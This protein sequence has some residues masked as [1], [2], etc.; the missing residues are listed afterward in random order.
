MGCGVT[1]LN[2]SGKGPAP[3]FRR[4][5]AAP[6]AADHCSSRPLIVHLQSAE[7]LPPAPDPHADGGPLV[8][9]RALRDGKRHGCE[10]CW[11]AVAADGSHPVW[12]SARGL[13]C[14]FSEVDTLEVELWDTAERKMFSELIATVHIP[15]ADLVHGEFCEHHFSVRSRRATVR[16]KALPPPPARKQVFFVRHGESVWNHA[17]Q[18]RDVATMLG[19]VNHPLTETGRD[20]AV[21][22]MQQIRARAQQP[23]EPAGG[24]E[25]ARLELELLRA[26]AVWSSPLMRAVQTALIAGHPL[27]VGEGTQQRRTLRLCAKARERR[28]FGGRDSTG[29]GRGDGFRELV[30]RSMQSLLPLPN[31]GKQQA[32]EMRTFCHE[33][34]FDLT[35]V[36]AKWWSSSRESAAAVR[37]RMEE[38]LMQLRYCPE[39][40]VVVFG[41]S[42][43][44]RELFR[45]HVREDAAVTGATLTDLCKTVLCNC[46]VAAVLMDFSSG[47]AHPIT[48]VDLIFNSGLGKLGP[49]TPGE[50]P[51]EA[52]ERRDL[53]LLIFLLSAS[54]IPRLDQGGEGES[55]VRCRALKG[56]AEVGREARWP[57]RR[58]EPCPVWNSARSLGCLVGEADH[59]G[60][61]LWDKDVLSDDHIASRKVPLAGLGLD[62]LSEH[63]FPC[64]G[65]E[66]TLRL[67]LLPQPATVKRVYFVRHGES[68]WNHAQRGG[69]LC[70]VVGAVD[71]PLSETGREQATG[72]MEH[73]LAAT[74]TPGTME[75]EMLRAEAVWSSPLIRCV[76]TAILGLHPLLRTGGSQ[77]PLR[78]CRAA[79]EKRNFG[80][81]DTSGAAVGEAYIRQV[82]ERTAALLPLPNSKLPLEDELRQLVDDVG[83]DTAEVQSQWWNDARESAGEL[84]GRMEEFMLQLQ[85]CTE[86]SVVVVGHSLFFREVLRCYMKDGADCVGATARQLRQR[87]L[88]NCGVAAATIDFAAPALSSAVIAVQLLFGSRLRDAE[89]E[90]GEGDAD[91]PGAAGAAAAPPLP[92][93]PPPPGPRLSGT[94]RAGTEE[95]AD[96]ADHSGLLLHDKPEGEQHPCQPVTLPR[97]MMP[98]VPPD[99]RGSG[100]EPCT[101]SDPGGHSPTSENADPAC[102]SG[103]DTSPGPKRRKSKKGKTKKPRDSKQ[104]N[105]QQPASVPADA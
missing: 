28:N 70:S 9:V 85:Y 91:P 8:R 65:K 73:L 30:V 68:E 100:S 36:Q 96:T 13:G 2:G 52:D 47:V 74:Q 82:R 60:L 39:R 93:L 71:H 75:E 49:P 105:E 29:S 53:P 27:L 42:H 87:V 55:Y 50:P 101:E 58:G 98:G 57:V 24:S 48:R 61:E 4:P 45:H 23:E 66:V 19:A 5:E 84:R 64:K 92:P 12:N 40:T 34:D 80:G 54:N 62:L 79:R 20:Q 22:L 11:A 37:R 76:Q 56:G 15:L 31:S 17:S 51:E 18:Q 38:F 103:A 1:S 46:G 86:E 97:D 81:R 90:V 14:D 21:H 25:E 35:E 99:H 94:S 67:K 83:I 41:H 104:H 7:G 69:D 16:L 26:E 6:G 95:N 32:E 102:T 72:L 3:E 43:F 10:A 63:R 88:G 89:P 78:L 59:I 44:F 77:L 33:V